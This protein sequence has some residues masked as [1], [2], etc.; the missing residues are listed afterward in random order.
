MMRV[1]ARVIKHLFTMQSQVMKRLEV[2]PS[3]AWGAKGGRRL[4]VLVEDL[5]LAAEDQHRARPLHEAVREAL[6]QNTW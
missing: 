1:P 3:G 6:Q 5:H 4:V 2:R